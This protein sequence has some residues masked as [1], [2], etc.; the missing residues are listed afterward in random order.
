MINAMRINGED[1]IRYKHFRDVQPGKSIRFPL[2][3]ER[4]YYPEKR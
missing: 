2:T 1:W 4:L 3:S